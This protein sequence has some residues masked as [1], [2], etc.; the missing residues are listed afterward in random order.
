MAYIYKIENQINHKIYIGKTEHIDPLQRWKEHQSDSKR[1]RCNHR[2]LYRA[3]NKYGIDNFTFE[4]IE[5]TDNPEE[6]EMFYI[7]FYDTYHNGYNETLG[8][9]GAKYVELPEQEVCKYYLDS[10]TLDETAK[11][12]GH[13][14]SLIKQVLYKYNIS[15]I[16]S[17][18]VMKQR[19]S[20]A[21]AKIDIKTN[22]ILSVY[23]SVSEAERENKNCHFHI[24]DVCHG[25]RKTAGGYKWQFIDN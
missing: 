19:A 4:V 13:D 18:E 14:V 7:S 10:H 8:G 12:F 25:K 3:M 15:I 11:H 9:D 24:K 6:R 22:Q 1:E 21:V 23:S 17:S 2:A 16:S 20:K 5:E